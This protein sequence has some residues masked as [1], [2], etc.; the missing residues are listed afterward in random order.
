MEANEVKLTQ[1]QIDSFNRDGFVI[2][3]KLISADQV[4]RLKIEVDRVAQRA[5]EMDRDSGGFNFEKS[6]DDPLDAAARI[7]AAGVLR[8]IQGIAEQSEAFGELARSSKVLDVVKSLIGPDISLHSNK[9][10][11]K[12]ARYGSAKPWHQDYAYWREADPVQI[13]VWIAIDEATPENG[14]VQ[15]I[16]ESHRLK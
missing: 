14:C 2:V 4:E 6:G 10:M 8:K 1:D 3:E 16:P 11:F 7:K 12:P 15:F 5:L 13:S 9:L